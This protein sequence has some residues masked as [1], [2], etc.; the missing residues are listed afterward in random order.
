MGRVVQ[1]S[2]I[3]AYFC[4]LKWS[5]GEGWAFSLHSYRESTRRR[6]VLLRWG[7]RPKLQDEGGKQDCAS[8]TAPIPLLPNPGLAELR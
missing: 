4:K 7:Q 3:L 6:I 5:F 8:P 1:T 2:R